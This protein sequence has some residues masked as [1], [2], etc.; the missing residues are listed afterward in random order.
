MDV[1]FAQDFSTAAASKVDNCIFNGMNTTLASLTVT[2]RPTTDTASATNPAY[3]GEGL[4]FE[5]TPATGSVG[6]FA[7]ASVSIRGV[8]AS[9]AGSSTWLKRATA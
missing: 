6:D 8:A 2:F 1:E 3:V 5:Y 9:S 4:V 7:T